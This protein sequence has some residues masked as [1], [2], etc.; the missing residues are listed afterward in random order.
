[1][2]WTADARPMLLILARSVGLVGAF[3]TAVLWLVFVFFNPYLSPDQAPDPGP[4]VM[5]AMMV[6][7][8]VAAAWAVLK[9]RTGILFL[10]FAASFVP[11]GFYVL[12]TP[13]IFKWI[14]VCNLLYLVAGLLMLGARPRVD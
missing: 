2:R 3:S 7:L 1:M 10:A 12:L 4:Y 11:V 5:G 13:S 9:L 14:G 8:S 6:L